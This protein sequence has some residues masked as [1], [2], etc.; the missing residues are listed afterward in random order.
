MD[1]GAW[2]GSQALIDSILLLLFFLAA[3][4]NVGCWEEDTLAAGWTCY[5]QTC[6]FR[7]DGSWYST[8]VV[9]HSH[10]T[11]SETVSHYRQLGLLILTY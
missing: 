5:P 6:L 7:K 11:L 9:L 3:R 4:R 1:D 2:G 8:T 10:C